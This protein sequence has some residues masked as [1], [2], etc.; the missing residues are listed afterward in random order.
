MISEL[1]T[2]GDFINYI[3]ERQF[4]SSL[5]IQNYT[6]EL[7]ILA[8]FISQYGIIEDLHNGKYDTL[9][10]QTG[11]WEEYRIRN[12]DKIQKRDKKKFAINVIDITIKELRSLIDY[13][14]ENSGIDIKT[15]TSKYF[16]LLGILSLLTCVEAIQITEKFV[17]KLESSKREFIR[18]F[19]YPKRECGIL[20]LI[21]NEPNREKRKNGLLATVGKAAQHIK[22]T[23]PDYDM[24]EI[25][26]IATE[27]KQLP[28]RSLDIVNMPMEDALS[29]IDPSDKTVLFKNTPK[30]RIDEWTM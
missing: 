4:L 21:I 16:H 29:L 7:D 30:K 14:I 18:Y 2:G 10:I 1:N 28:G 26:G 11:T 22:D 25:I 6:N 27:G 17:E 15:I 19:M 23:M 8:I 20:F 9:M 5:V 12:R 24:K 3:K 13:T